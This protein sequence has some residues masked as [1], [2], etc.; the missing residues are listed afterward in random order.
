MK[1]SN[2]ARFAV[3]AAVASTIGLVSPGAASASD[4]AVN[5]KSKELGQCLSWNSDGSTTTAKCGSAYKWNDI[6]ISPGVWEEAAFKGGSWCLDYGSDYSSAI[7][8]CNANSGNARQQWRELKYAK[9]WMLKNVYSGECL[10]AL[11]IQKVRTVPCNKND[12]AQYWV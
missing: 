2:I 3:V 1:I 5:W 8:H 6:E 11:T 4:G 7:K 12:S 10:A 9:G